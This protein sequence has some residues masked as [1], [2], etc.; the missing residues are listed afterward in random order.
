MF[1]CAQLKSSVKTYLAFSHVKIATY[2]HQSCFFLQG[3][4]EASLSSA[5]D[6]C[7]SHDNIRIAYT[8]YYKW[9]FSYLIHT[10][11]SYWFVSYII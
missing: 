2:T 6:L 7:K 4:H 9:Y 11:L 8:G 1:L 10:L 5:V 3:L